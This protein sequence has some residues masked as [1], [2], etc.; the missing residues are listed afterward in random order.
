MVLIRL[1][2]LLL[3]K[4]GFIK[5]SL[6][7]NYFELAKKKEE[8]REEL[9]EVGRKMEEFPLQELIF[10]VI[11]QYSVEGISS[12][13]IPKELS[14]D[15]FGFILNRRAKQA[16]RDLVNEGKISREDDGG[17]KRNHQTVYRYIP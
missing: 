14:M 3:I 8:L 11:K 17:Y 5:L 7:E 6:L 10:E 13:D 12:L 2:R 15:P 16:L 1:T 4:L 9:A